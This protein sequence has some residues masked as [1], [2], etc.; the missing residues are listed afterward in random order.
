M[1]YGRS[2][3]V[4]IARVLEYNVLSSSLLFIYVVDIDRKVETPLN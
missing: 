4:S 1:V 2:T 3:V